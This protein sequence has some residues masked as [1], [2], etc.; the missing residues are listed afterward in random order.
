[1]R[2]VECSHCT[3]AAA[4][5]LTQALLDP[6][7]AQIVINRKMAEV[8]LDACDVALSREPKKENEHE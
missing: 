7:A 1:M 8:L 3:E 2:T 5:I 4:D 6:R